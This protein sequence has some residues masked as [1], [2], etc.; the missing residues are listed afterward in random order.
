M[1]SSLNPRSI[2]VEDGLGLGDVST[3][4]AAT[5][6]S[7]AEPS[8]VTSIPVRPSVLVGIPD[9]RVLSVIS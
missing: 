6:L 5:E 7:R 9:M 4:L 2:V 1:R 8:T 3:M